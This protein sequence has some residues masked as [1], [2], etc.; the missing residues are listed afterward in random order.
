MPV[1]VA[2]GCS[3]Y[4]SIHVLLKLQAAV[5]AYECSLC[6]SVVG[7]ERT[8]HSCRS[9]GDIDNP[10]V[11]TAPKFRYQH[12]RPEHGLR[13]GVRWGSFSLRM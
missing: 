8:V 13:L 1:L 11:S 3:E 12:V 4:I 6:S 10:A 9:R 5:G 2:P 7:A